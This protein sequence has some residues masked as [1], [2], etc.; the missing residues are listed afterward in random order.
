MF[1]S[2]VFFQFHKQLAYIFKA[3]I[4]HYPHYVGIICQPLSK[5]LFIA[6][7]DTR[8]QNAF[9]AFKILVKTLLIW[10]FLTVRSRGGSTGAIG[11]IAP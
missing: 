8:S 5:F 7:H 1:H 4:A 3:Q 11:A 6:L 9:T 10:F 2:V